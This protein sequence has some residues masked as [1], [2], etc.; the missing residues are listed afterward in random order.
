M[1]ALSER[2]QL[3]DWIGRAVESGA[4][5]AQACQTIGLSPRTLQR[6]KQPNQL[7]ADRRT[8]RQYEPKNKLSAHEVEQIIAVAN[9]DEFNDLSPHQIV[10]IL[11]E[12]GEYIASESTFYRVLKS[13][14]QLTHRHKSR[15]PGSKPSKPKAFTAT[16][17]NQVY[18]WD[19]TYLASTV[20]GKFFYLYLFM[21]IF[22]RKIVGWQVFEQES[23]R[24][25]SA[26]ITDICRQECIPKDQL[27]LHSDNGSPMKGATMLAT[28]QK[29]GIIPSLSRP[30]VSNDNP[31]S[32][33][34]FKTLKYRPDYPSEPFES[35][36][37]ARRWVAVFVTW[38]NTKHRHSGIQFVTPD[39][40]HRGEDSAILTTRR[41]TYAAAQQANPER[42]SRQVR[43]WCWAPVEY[44]NPDK[45]RKK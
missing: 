32:E 45:E 27:V 8:S 13:H 30:S 9:R 25:A 24:H 10:A 35:V 39:Q 37:D 16:A 20:K 31:Y 41:E 2:K 12:R 38:Y 4:R 6:W 19:I 17:P 28:L 5:H 14:Q 7:Q 43:D 44:L 40:R 36:I 15:V 11:A 33:A 23:S 42:W 1:I 3:I 22:S 18:S 21:D 29:L 34:L 26:I